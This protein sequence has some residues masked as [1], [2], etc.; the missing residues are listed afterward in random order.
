MYFDNQMIRIINKRINNVI[1]L[2][3]VKNGFYELIECNF[4]KTFI[5]IDRTI[6]II[7][8]ILFKR[9]HFIFMTFEL[10]H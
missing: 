9:K 6:V 1:A 3:Y 8:K 7:T 2:N 5:S 4:D 10:I